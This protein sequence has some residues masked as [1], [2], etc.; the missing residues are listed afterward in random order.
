VATSTVWVGKAAARLASMVSNDSLG[1]GGR[2][3]R[4]LPVVMA[5]VCCAA[6]SMWVGVE[7]ILCFALYR[8]L[9]FGCF[10]E[11]SKKSISG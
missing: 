2:L 7:A 10:E 9:P 4:R 1:R 5:A 6:A 11:T 3:T 8:I